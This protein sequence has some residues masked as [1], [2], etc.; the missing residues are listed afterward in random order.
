MPLL[1]IILCYEFRGI[2]VLEGWREQED[3]MEHVAY[4]VVKIH[5][6]NH[7]ISIYTKK[8]VTRNETW[9]CLSIWCLFSKVATESPLAMF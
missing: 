5:I 9:F 3:S 8:E 6:H 7:T 2:I 4:A 1:S